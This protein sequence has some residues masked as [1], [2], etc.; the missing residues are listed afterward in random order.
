MIFYI[1]FAYA[2]LKEKYPA[3]G[4]LMALAYLIR[5]NSV[6]LIPATLIWMFIHRRRALFGAPA[7]NS[8]A[9]R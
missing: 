6:M 9:P 7:L 8:S 1:L 5:N 4:L 2:L 3:A